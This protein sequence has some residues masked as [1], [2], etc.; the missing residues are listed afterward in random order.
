MLYPAILYK[1]FNFYII[2][3]YTNVQERD[4][5]W[6]FIYMDPDMFKMKLDIDLNVNNRVFNHPTKGEIIIDNIY[7]MN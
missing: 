4:Y 2:I 7:H 3:S 1:L 6:D 5:Q